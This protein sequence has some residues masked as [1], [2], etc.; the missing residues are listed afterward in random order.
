[1]AGHRRR[2]S[3]CG[4]LQQ[5]DQ[6]ALTHLLQQ[7]LPLP[8][9]RRRSPDPCAGP[10]W[11][12]GPPP[13]GWAAARLRPA[14]PC[15]AAAPWTTAGGGPCRGCGCG[16]GPALPQPLRPPL[17]P[18]PVPGPGALRCDP[19]CGCGCAFG[20]PQAHSPGCTAC[21]CRCRVRRHRCC[22]CRRTRGP[23]TALASGAASPPGPGCA[24]GCGCGCG[25]DTR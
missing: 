8:A 3:G 23:P 1:M 16:C 14:A 18:R 17:L 11:G 6:A 25:R 12:P 9:C 7:H 19:G 2:P 4:V 10:S 15:H 21:H 20:A 24:R 13:G 22:C 5:R